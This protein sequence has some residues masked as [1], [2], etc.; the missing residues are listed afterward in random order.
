MS[1]VTNRQQR[2]AQPL[3]SWARQRH[4]SQ[5][6]ETLMPKGRQA[7]SLLCAA[8]LPLNS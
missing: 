5:R 2:P 3:K 1:P 4:S 7:G 8:L 6:V